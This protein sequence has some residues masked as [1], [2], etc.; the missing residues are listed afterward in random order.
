MTMPQRIRWAVLCFPVPATLVPI[1]YDIAMGCF[2]VT[3]WLLILAAF[4]L[5][6]AV[7]FFVTRRMESPVLLLSPAV[8]LCAFEV[9]VDV[10]YMTSASSTTG[11]VFLFAPL[12]GLVILGVGLLGGAL[13]RLVSG[14]ARK[15][16]STRGG[17]G[18]SA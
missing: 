5:P 9:L 2:Q 17:A 13:A 6:N 7:Y 10:A 8:P 11:L 1:G 16:G 12:Y 14:K 15:T 4:L 18:R 3:G